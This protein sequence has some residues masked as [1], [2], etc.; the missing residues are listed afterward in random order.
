MMSETGKGM[1]RQ[2]YSRRNFIKTAALSVGAAQALSVIG[3]GSAR[4]ASESR[5]QP[6]SVAGYLGSLQTAR[7]R[8]FAEKSA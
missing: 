1:S 5:N 8:F 3:L 2:D 4:A 6:L 7:A